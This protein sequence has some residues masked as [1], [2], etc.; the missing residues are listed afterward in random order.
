MSNENASADKKEKPCGCSGELHMPELNKECIAPSPMPW[1]ECNN[2]MKWFVVTN[3]EKQGS[4]IIAGNPNST[5]S[6]G[7]LVTPVTVEF[8]ITYQFSL[9]LRGRQPGKL[10]YTTS[11]IPQ[12]ELKIYISDRFRKT[13]S[14][15]AC[16]SSQ[17]SLRQSV[18]ALQQS[19]SDN[20]SDYTS[21][22]NKSN[23]EGA[24]SLNFLG[25][26]GGSDSSGSSSTQ[27]AQSLAS[28]MQSFHQTLTA[29]S[30]SVEAQRS[31][32]VSSYEDQD[33][34]Q[35]TSRTLKNFNHTR[36]VTYYVRQINE[37]YDLSASI[38]SIRWRII[39]S[40]VKD[41]PTEWQSVD[42]INSIQNLSLKKFIKTELEQLP[43]LNSELKSDICFTLPADGTVLETELAH[44]SS[45]D[46]EK[47]LELELSLERSKAE[48]RKLLLEGEL[49][50]FEIER[51][52]KLLEAG[53]LNEFDQPV[54]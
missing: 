38:I 18:S 35:T 7:N 39:E 48:T 27:T 50:Q 24:A 42:D 33:N 36:A 26:F 11:L 47:M 9:C 46:A 29:A 1:V 2:C 6:K 5:N 16:V 15:T 17:S 51:R 8:E 34:L 4:I 49:M 40:R 23:S 30:S 41:F 45:V 22:I 37:V 28:S 13:T 31:I 32:V 3:V 14:A 53:N 12:E 19:Q 21:N 44:C 43:K 20:S 54:A 52:K 10:L 25:L